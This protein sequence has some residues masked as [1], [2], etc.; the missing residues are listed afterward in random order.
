MSKDSAFRRGDPASARVS[1]SIAALRDCARVVNP[2][3]LSW[4]IVTSG[5]KTS[6]INRSSHFRLEFFCLVVRDQ[7]F[8]QGINLAFHHAFE[9]VEREANAVIRHTVLREVVGSDFF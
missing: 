8:N 1:V 6:S 2:A 4:A 3:V 7:G 9:L 5:I